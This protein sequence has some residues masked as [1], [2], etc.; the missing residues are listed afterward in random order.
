[1]RAALRACSFIDEVERETLFRV[2]WSG[3]VNGL[4]DAIEESD[5]VVLEGVGKG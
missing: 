4:L 3:E 1:V 5:G 2:A